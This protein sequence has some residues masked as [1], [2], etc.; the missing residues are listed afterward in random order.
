MLVQ[1]WKEFLPAAELV[2]L[3][4]DRVCARGWHEKVASAGVTL[5]VGDQSNTTLL[6]EI[7]LHEETKGLDVII[8]DGGHTMAQ[9][10]T[11]LQVLWE[12]V[13]PGGF[14]VVEDL[15]TSYLESFGGNSQP[16][17]PNTTVSYVTS[18]LN[19][20]NCKDAEDN[21]LQ[22]VFCTDKQKSLKNLLS[23]HCFSG[24]CAFFKTPL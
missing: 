22:F 15:L 10:L 20:L 13:R 5:Y 9:Q 18:Q 17:A 14:Y 1:V 16:G 24:L 19:F 8:D 4:F 12:L 21:G 11:S 3:E 23:I 7:V 2:Y 6:Q